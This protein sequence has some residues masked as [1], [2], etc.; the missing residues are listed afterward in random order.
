MYNELFAALA[1]AQAEFG[2][3]GLNSA[4]PFYNSRYAD[5]AEIVRVT[6]P[7]LTKNGLCVLQRVIIEADYQVLATTLG[8]S[9][10]Q[11]MQ[12]EMKINIPKIEPEIELNRPGEKKK[13]PKSDVQAI[14]SYITY[15]KR[16]AYAAI[17]G[18]VISDE[19]DDGEGAMKSYRNDSYNQPTQKVEHIDYITIE[20]HDLLQH[21]L[22]EMP[23][24]AGSILKS[25]N[26]TALTKLPK[27]SYHEVIDIID[28][29]KNMNVPSSEL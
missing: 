6:R 7:A 12:S 13:Q 20:Q 8:H 16:Y 10:G 27:K 1:K 22:K 15:L 18:V 19:D 26:I 14:G 29:I 23:K 4:N 9:S 28:S 2:I 3:A 17:V 25:Y 11:F 24:A 21:K 5:F